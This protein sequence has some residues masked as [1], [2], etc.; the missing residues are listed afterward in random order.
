MKPLIPSDFIRLIDVLVENPSIATAPHVE[1]FHAL[2][3]LD[4]NYAAVFATKLLQQ[5]DDRVSEGAVSEVHPLYFLARAAAALRGSDPPSAMAK[6]AAA[7]ALAV[8][9]MHA[10]AYEK[11]QSLYEP[12]RRAVLD[13]MP[14]ESSVAAAS[15]T[16]PWSSAS[17]ATPREEWAKTRQVLSLDPESH[18]AMDEL[19]ELVGRDCSSATVCECCLAYYR[20]L[21]ILTVKYVCFAGV[22][23]IKQHAL[24]AIIDH[25][26]LNVRSDFKIS[27]PVKKSLNALYTGNPGKKAYL[28]SSL[29]P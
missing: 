23:S 5:Y 14:E 18:K 4:N 2:A 25:Y 27:A 1:L 8:F 28:L 15:A 24:T 10:P 16:S 21:Y 26:L 6:K 12:C 13:I 11:W 7:S 22:E 9:R 29:R 20:H 3:L 17:P 19:I